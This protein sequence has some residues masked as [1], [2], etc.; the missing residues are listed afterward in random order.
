MTLA[1]LLL[2]AGTPSPPPDATTTQRGL[3][4]TKEQAF[5]GL[6]T[7]DGG[8][9]SW[10][11]NG[12]TVGPTTGDMDL[13][14]SP[15]GSDSNLCTAAS[16]C[17]TV[18]GVFR[19]V[20]R[21]VKH[22]VRIYAD[23]GTYGPESV[24]L[25]GLDL[26]EF[27]SINFF[28]VPLALAP[29][30]GTGTGTLT[31]VTNTLPSP[32]LVD[33]TQA[34]VPNSLRGAQVR[35][36]SGAA[37][38]N[39]G[40]ITSNT[41]TQLD[42]AGVVSG[43]VAIGNGYELLVPG[44]EITSANATTDSL[45][46]STLTFRNIAGRGTA[47]P[48]TGGFDGGTYGAITFSWVRARQ[49]GTTATVVTVNEV[50]SRVGFQDS[51]LEGTIS[52]IGRNQQIALQR[53]IVRAKTSGFGISVAG[54]LQGLQGPYLL[55][56]L[57]SNSVCLSNRGSLTVS[58]STGNVI[59]V[60]AGSVGGVGNFGINLRSSASA[61][62]GG[63]RIDCSGGAGYGLAFEGAGIALNPSAATFDVSFVSISNCGTGLR[64]SGPHI[65]S[66]ISSTI[67]NTTT[68]VLLERGARVRTVNAPAI[69]GVTSEIT[70]DGT[71]FTFA[72]LN[73]ASPQVVPTTPNVYGTWLSR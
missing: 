44:T 47:A 23:A 20:P 32:S 62:N 11:I 28:G 70:I 12:V 68:G 10:T 41:A 56:C 4:N 63:W 21:T 69:S 58:N 22:V 13:F 24:L 61:T 38:G 53:S 27:G 26:Q 18:N 16:P 35:L 60:P 72:T 8:I 40:V 39:T 3:V 71:A 52:S 67:T 73:A 57:S 34:W 9:A 45:N 19:R 6:K 36:T 54:E 2:L 30:G 65:G 51:F 59:L 1:L 43:T 15:A 31:G 7:F 64:F 29:D 17:R 25:E 66:V 33:S 14:L 49:T 5:S 55:D 42:L 37:A 48:T 50:G 46:A